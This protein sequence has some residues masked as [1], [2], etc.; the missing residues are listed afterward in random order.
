MSAT[1]DLRTRRGELTAARA[2][3]LLQEVLEGRRVDYDRII[4]S[5]YAWTPEAAEVMAGAI[6]KLPLLTD[7]VLADIIASKPEAE[8]L[9]V[10]RALGAAL[11]TKRLRLVDLSD[12]AVGTKGVDACREFLSEQETLEDLTFSNCG[13]SVSR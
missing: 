9:A 10:Y 7:A 1:L 12:N 6:L 13:L 2:K 3:E 11:R 5:D 4:L 8:G